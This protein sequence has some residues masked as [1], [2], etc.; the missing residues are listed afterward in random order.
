MTPECSTRA[1]LTTQGLGAWRCF[2]PG[3]R[4]TRRSVC[5][6]LK[7][8]A[9][10]VGGCSPGEAQRF[11][12]CLLREM[13]CLVCAALFVNQVIMSLLAF[14]DAAILISTNLKK[15]KLYIKLRLVEQLQHL[16]DQDVTEQ[17]DHQKER[18]ETHPT[19]V[20]RDKIEGDLDG[21]ISDGGKSARSERT[22]GGQGGYRSELSRRQN[23]KV[24]RRWAWG[25][26]TQIDKV[27]VLDGE[28][29]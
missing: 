5:T 1:S 18:G 25:V 11:N 9:L 28:V 2:A 22:W 17:K 8:R 12:L 24:G 21:Q 19:A 3:R 10:G 7:F 26:L 20:L 16:M 29:I 27:I 6:L 13:V 14:N 15:I 23:R 4:P